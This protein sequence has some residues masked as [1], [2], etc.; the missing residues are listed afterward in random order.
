MSRVVQ[1]E[2]TS[3]IL[4][5]VAEIAAVVAKAGKRLLVDAMSAFG[6]LPLDAREVQ[7]DAL[8]ASSNKCLEGVPGMG[9]VICRKTA[10]EACAGNAHSLSLDL[11]DQCATWRRRSSGASR[12]RRM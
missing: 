2:T 1:C 7:Y 11:H 9:F 10:L 12:R 4:N 8:A 6:A 3:G 5:P